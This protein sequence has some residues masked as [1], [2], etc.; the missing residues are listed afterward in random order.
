MFSERQDHVE[1]P[2]AWLLHLVLP[3]APHFLKQGIVSTWNVGLPWSPGT[4][5]Q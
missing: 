5:Y 1:K 4:E 2:G 3:P